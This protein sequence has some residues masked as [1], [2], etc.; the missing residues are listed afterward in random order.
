M[1]PEVH[2]TWQVGGVRIT[3]V[4]EIAAALPP[5]PPDALLTG[6]TR[7]LVRSLEWLHPHFATPDGQLVISLH[8]F[9]VESQGRRIMID[10]C[11]GNDKI[12]TSE[13]FNRLQGSFLSDLAAIGN[14]PERIDT[15]LCTHLH[16]DHVGW[17]TRL[18]DGKWVPTFP[19]ARYLF[20][21]AEW[22]YWSNAAPQRAGDVIGD[23]VRPIF[24]A[25]LAD[26]VDPPYRLTDEVSLEPTPGHTPGHLSVRIVSAGAEAV[27]TGDMVHHPLQCAHPRLGNPADVDADA[28][29]RTRLDLFGRCADRPVL[30]LGSHFA[31]PTGGWIVSDG[32]HWRFS[33]DR[34]A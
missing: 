22:A 32:A 17:N 24:D 4:V 25:G 19:N 30:V 3:K 8:G 31:P 15:V 14:P 9:V 28:A 27:I 26:L 10:T 33:T 29:W 23:S 12:R 16:V 7:D 21:R 20:G 11:I 2:R 34:P 1:A 13:R 5:M 6:A 18:V